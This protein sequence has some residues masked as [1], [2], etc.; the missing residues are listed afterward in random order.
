MDEAKRGRWQFSVRSL[1][2]VTAAVALL[3]VPVAWV[4]RERQQMLLAQREILPARELALRSAVLEHQRRLSQAVSPSSDFAPRVSSGPDRNL[5][6]AEKL[7]ALEQLKQ[8]NADLRQRLEQLRR[9]VETLKNLA[10][11]EGKP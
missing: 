2:L 11:P 4:T 1:L 6:Q 8:E 10:K 7:P 9:E 5:A 3:L